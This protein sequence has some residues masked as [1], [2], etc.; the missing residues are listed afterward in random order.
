MRAG[1]N[2]PAPKGLTDELMNQAI[3]SLNK[4]GT[5]ESRGPLGQ[6][7]I[8]VFS[9]TDDYKPADAPKELPFLRFEANL[10]PYVVPR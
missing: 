7:A 9:L 5:I 3:Y 6:G 4:L 2:L 8:E 10:I 1:V